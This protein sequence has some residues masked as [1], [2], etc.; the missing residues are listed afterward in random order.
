MGGERWN[1][2]PSS[3]VPVLLE[4]QARTV[5]NRAGRRQGR[6][7]EVRLEELSRGSVQ[8][9]TEQSRSFSMV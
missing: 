8:G 7:F 1:Y 3:V 5:A 6:A 9:R 2:Q 4:K